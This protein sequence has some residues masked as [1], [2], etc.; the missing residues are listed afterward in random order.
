MTML[1][2]VVAVLADKLSEGEYPAGS[3]VYRIE[4]T[5]DLREV[6]RAALLAIRDLDSG[7]INSGGLS[8]LVAGKEALYSCT[9]DPE[10]ADA[11]GCFHAMIDAILNAEKA[12]TP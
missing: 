7:D 1:D 6:A 9:A 5:F 12:A 10:L 3:G 4:G 11:R 8:A 2:N